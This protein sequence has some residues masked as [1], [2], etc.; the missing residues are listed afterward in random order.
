MTQHMR[1]WMLASLLSVI[2]A[3]AK[4]PPV[5]PPPT[6]PAVD[7]A[8]V[9]PGPGLWQVRSSD[10][11][12]WLV[13]TL[14]P[15]PKR[16]Q[17][18]SA[19]LDARLAEADA[20]LGGP[21][22]SITTGRGLLHAWTLVPSALG[23]RKLPDGKTLADVLAPELYGR[24]SKL[25]TENLGRDRAVERWRPMFAAEKLHRKVVERAGLS[26]TSLVA[27]HIA[28]A[29]KR[30]ELPRIDGSLALT[31]DEPRKALREFKQGEFEDIDCFERTLQRLES[32]LALLT[33]RAEAWAIGDVD[34]LRTLHDTNPDSACLEALTNAPVLQKLG[35]ADARAKARERWLEAAEQAL[36]AHRVT[37][38]AV[39][40]D[41]LLDAGPDGVLATFSARG[42]R[43]LGPD[44]F[45]D[46]NVGED[47]R[48]DGDPT[49]EAARTNAAP[50]QRAPAH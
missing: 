39:P 20:I 13:G 37:V 12:L 48:G 28:K 17:W 19:E 43:V 45:D 44:D 27:D 29:G 21:G 42:Y 3:Y 38:G 35:L 1:A 50:Q 41:L 2:P 49:R 40:I 30:R 8:G 9:M 31:L 25:K 46:S 24:W 6:L 16:M 4:S 33:A 7:V 47:V 15:L 11:V 5:E 36:G 23:A 14:N 32:D 22:L 10:H 34:S 18:R 26:F